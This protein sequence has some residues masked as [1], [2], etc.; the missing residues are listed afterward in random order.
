MTTAQN[1]M[2]AQLLDQVKTHGT[3]DFSPSV[4]RLAIKI[5]RHKCTSNLKLVG[6]GG[7]APV[8]R[9]IEAIESEFQQ[10]VNWQGL[11]VEDLF[12]L[13]L[14]HSGRLEVKNGSILTQYEHVMAIVLRELSLEASPLRQGGFCMPRR[15]NSR[16]Q[17]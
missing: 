16:K 12:D 17:F 7:W 15:L 2:F 6:D 1:K 10:N 14:K 8:D 13:A 4:L 11:G 3:I 5:L 9:V